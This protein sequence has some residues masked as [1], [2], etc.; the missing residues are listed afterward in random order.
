MSD[1]TAEQIRDFAIRLDPS[2]AEAVGRWEIAVGEDSYGKPGLFITIVLRD[3]TIRTA[4]KARDAF[5]WRL[6][7]A[8]LAEVPGYYPFIGFSAESIAINPESP[9]PA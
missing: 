3:A 6:F 2:F 1:P 5:R 8:L 4:W 9:V 7:D